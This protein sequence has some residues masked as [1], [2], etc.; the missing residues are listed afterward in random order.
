MS[1]E[2]LISELEQTIHDLRAQLAEA[3]LQNVFNA[4]FAD[5]L[6]EFGTIDR[7]LES[8]TTQKMQLREAEQDRDHYKALVATL[9]DAPK[10]EYG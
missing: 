9:K 5:K 4:A 2:R 8:Y 3:K 7:L 6:K 10:P 1:T